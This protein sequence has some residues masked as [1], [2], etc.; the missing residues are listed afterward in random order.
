MTCR[1]AILISGAGSNMCALVRSMS[2]DHPA[3]PCVV[4]SDND[5]AKGLQRALAQ[6]VP[7]VTVDYRVYGHDRGAFERA[8]IKHLE[9]YQADVVCLAGFMRILTA[10]FVRCWRGRIV[11][12]HP[13]LLPKFKGLNT[14]RRVLEAGERYHGCTVHAVTAELDSGEILGQSHLE[15]FETDTEQSLAKRVLKLEHELYPAVLR[16]FV[17]SMHYSSYAAHET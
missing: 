2:A 6:G 10:S 9:N 17:H 15:V 12:I 14:H 4:I 8:L 13:S 11:N 1:V 7:T 16:R 3:R 5:K